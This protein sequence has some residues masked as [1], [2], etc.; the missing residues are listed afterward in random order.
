MAALSSFRMVRKPTYDP[1]QDL[2]GRN[3]TVKNL[4]DYHASIRR[5]LGRFKAM[6]AFT[7]ELALDETASAILLVRS[8]RCHVEL[9]SEVLDAILTQL[10]R[11]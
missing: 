9:V 4:L 11:S 1:D 5:P 8:L 10:L 3:A 7:K 6:L 2:P